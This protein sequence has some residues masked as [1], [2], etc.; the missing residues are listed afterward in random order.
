M[1][2]SDFMLFFRTEWMQLFDVRIIGLVMLGTGILCLPYLCEKQTSA[3]WQEIFG[4]NAM[5]AGY[6]EAF[7]MVFSSMNT[8]ELI[9]ERLL[10]EIAMD[11]RPI[12]YGYVLYI[13][14]Y[15]E[16]ADRKTKKQPKVQT[17]QP[18]AEVSPGA[19]AGAEEIPG[20]KESTCGKEAAYETEKPWENGNLTRREK[21]VAALAARGLS[22][23][24]IADELC[25]SETTVKKHM[26]NI[27]EKL[28]ID[29]REKLNG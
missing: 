17:R 10:R 1:L 11:L 21:E 8:T 26:S 6:L 2:Y 15:R 29:S 28:N 24:E 5:M 25:I 22:N 3:A 16:D 4:K 20:N 13:I 7:F 9:W 19:Q 18:E 14:F 12:F 23:R 27:F